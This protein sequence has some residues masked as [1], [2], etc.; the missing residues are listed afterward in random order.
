MAS[1]LSPP[2]G[3]KTVLLFG[4][5]AIQ[6]D[7]NDFCHLR[8]VILDTPDNHWV[9][10]V[11]AELPVYWRTAIKFLPALQALPGEQQLRDLNQWIRS[12]KVADHHFPL[13]YLQHAPLL[14]ITHLLQFAR[15]L[16]LTHPDYVAHGVV[17]TETSPVVEI[18][19]FSFG[20]L[21]AAVASAVTNRSRLQEYGAAG[22]RLALL[23]GALGDAQEI[24]EKYTSLTTV[25]KKPEL[26]GSLSKVLEEH[27]EAYIT[28][29]YDANRA[30]IMTPRSSLGR[31]QQSLQAAG[32]SAY[33][34][35]FNGRYH[36]PGH[37]KL[38][39]G[40]FQMC[41]ADVAL[42]LP[43]A[44]Q[45]PRHTWTNITN[46]PI[47]EGPLH[48]LVLRSILAQQCQWGPTF[49]AVHG[50]QLENTQ[51]IVVE[52]GSERCV[53]P[54]FLR[55]LG[56]RVVH[57][58]DLS[59]DFQSR[60]S[61]L[62]SAPTIYD[63]DIAVV[64]MAC[65][66]AGADDLEE[67]WKILCSGE[68]QHREMPP[69]RY[70]GYETPWRPGAIRPW[71]GNFVSDID[72]FDH[73]FFKKV[74]REV[75]SQ[76]PQQRLFLQVA[77]QALQQAGYFHKKITSKDIGCYVTCCTVDYEH[78]VNCHAA[79]AYAATGLLRSFLAG[80]VSHYFGWHGPA[81]CIDTACSGSA[82]ALHHA[83]RAILQGDCKAALVGGANAITSPLAYD[84]LNGASF[85]SPTG[86]CKPFDEKADGYCRGEGF[87]AIFIKRMS[88]ALADGD[89]I[90][91]TIAATAVEQNDNCTPLVVPH[92][93][94]LA[95]LF[96][97]VIRQSHIRPHEISVVEAHGTGTQAGDPAE[98]SSVRQVMGGPQRA[99]PLTLGSVKGLVGHTEAVS[100]MVALVKVLLMINEGKLPPQPNF[101]TLNPHIQAAADD[102]IEITT[103]LKPWQTDFRAA[104]INNYG[105]CGSNASMVVTQPPGFRSRRSASAIH[106]PDISL[107][108][109]FCALDEHR[110]RDYARKFYCLLQ[111]QIV[112]TNHLASLAN[113]SFNVARQSSPMLDKHLIFSCSSLKELES[114][115]LS[116]IDGDESRTIQMRKSARPVVLCFG[117]QVSTSVGLDR[118]VYDTMSILRKHL[119]E[120]SKIL[121]SLGYEGLYPSIFESTPVTDQV[122][123]QTQLFALQY[124]SARSWMDCGLSVTAVVGHSFGELT[125]LCISE[126]L[127]LE[128]ALI[129]VA[130]RATLIRD[131]WGTNPGAMMAVEGEL[132][133]IEHLLAEAAVSVPTGTSPA[134]IACF[135]SPRSYTLAGATEAMSAVRVLLS[136]QPE[137]SRLKYKSLDVTNAFHS[138]LIDPLIPELMRTTNGLTFREPI[139]HLER[140]T[141]DPCT[142]VPS[143]TIVAEHLRQ[144]VYFTQA[145]ARLA[146]KYKSCIWL[147]AGS[148]STITVMAS[149]ALGSSAAANHRF[150]AVN[151]TTQNGVQSLTDNTIALWKEGVSVSYWAHH[152]SQTPEYDFIFLPPYQFEKSR[153]WMENKPLPTSSPM[154][155]PEVKE[156][157]PQFRF[158]GYQD[159]AKRVA[160]F[161]I[162]TTH[163]SYREAVSGHIG[164]QTAPLAPASFMLDSV[165]EALRSLP[166]GK[167][168]VPQVKNVTSDAPLGLDE[169]QNVHITLTAQSTDKRVWDMEYT[170]E[171][172]EKGARSRVLHCAARIKMFKADDPT[173]QGE[174]SRYGR[175]VSHRRCRELLDS[176]DVDDILQ[177]RNVYRAFSEVVDYA[178]PYRGVHKLVGKGN[179]SAGRVV[180]KYSGRTW[181]DTF[182]CDSFSQVGG[183][184]INCMTDRSASQIY[185]ASGMELWMRTPLYA[186]PE[187]PR[188]ETWDVLATHE[189]GD[190]FYTSDIFVFDSEKGQLV[191]TFI[192]MKYSCVPKAV[193]SKILSK[194]GSSATP[195]R[196][197]GA[198]TTK[199]D[200]AP[201]VTTSEAVSKPK[202]SKGQA[203]NL[204]VRI[205]GVVA[206]FCAV[207]PS[208]IHDDGNMADAGVDS[209]MAMELAR[210]MEEVFKCTL[211]AT[212]LVEAETFR[213][214]VRAVQNAIGIEPDEAAFDEDQSSDSGT[215]SY[216]ECDSESDAIDAATTESVTSMSTDTPELHLP[217]DLILDAFAET[218]ALTDK[219][220][221]ENHCSGRVLS[222]NPVQMQLCVTMTLEAFEEL[223]SPIRSARPGQRLE[224]IKFDAQH[225]ELVQYLYRRLEEARLVQL[226][227][228]AIV[229]TSLEWTTMSS[230]AILEEIGRTYPEFVGASKLAFYTGNK[231]ASVLRGERDGLQLIFG[232]KEGQE[233]VSWMYGDESHNVSGYKQMLDFLQRL[234]QKLGSRPGT[235]PLK[236]LEMGAGT[237]GGTKWF[238]P[239]LAKLGIPIEYTFTDISPAFLAQARRRFKEYPFVQYRVHDIEKPPADDL[240][241]TQHVI[242][243]SNAVHA[244]S[245]LQISTG[246]MRRALRPDG[247]VMM[248]EMTRPQFA[249]DIV[250]GLFRGWWVFNDGRTHAITSEHRWE[251]DLHAVG[252]GHVDW[253]DGHS[254]EASIQRVIFATSTGEQRGRLPLGPYLSH[255]S[256][257]AS[258]DN[259][260]RNQ[261]TDKYI[262]RSI[263]GFTEPLAV[264]T[265]V[266]GPVAVL[267]TGATGS[268]GSH[269]VAHLVQLQNVS[270]V[271]CL[272]R[273]GKKDPFQRQQRAF[274]E[275]RLDLTPQE[276]DKL[277][278]IET[279]MGEKQLG[280][281]E[282]QY[283]FVQTS[284][285]HII[286]NAWP[287]N[288]ARG[289][290]GFDSQFQ[291]MRNLVELARDIASVRP[292]KERVGFQ[293]ISSIGTVGFRPLVTGEPEVPEDRTV[294]DWVLANGYGE[295][296]FVCERTLHHT[297]MKYPKRFNAM[298]VRPGQIAG[299]S[300]SGYWN[301]A[302]HL[303]ALLKS[304]QAI[305]ALPDFGG[306]LSW[307]PV[308]VV[309]A[310]LSE[311]LF[312]EEAHSVYH[313][314]NAA[315]QPWREMMPILAQE[316]G[317]PK[318]NLLPFPEW[319]QRVQ[320]FEGPREDNPAGVMA[321]WLAN[322]FERMSCGGL[323]LATARAQ[324][325]ASTLQS[326]GP[327]DRETVRG[328]VQYWHDHDWRLQYC[329]LVS[330]VPVKDA[331]ST[332]PG[333]IHIVPA[334]CVYEPTLNAV[335]VPRSSVRP[336][337]FQ[338]KLLLVGPWKKPRRRLPST[339][340]RTSRRQRQAGK[341]R[342]QKSLENATVGNSV[343]TTT[344]LSRS[345]DNRA[346][347]NPRASSIEPGEAESAMG[348]ARKICELGSQH[349]DEQNTSAIPGYSGSECVLPVPGTAANRQPISAILG[350]PFP[351]PEVMYSLLDEY[352]DAVHWFSLVIYEPKFRRKL[353]T[354]AD[355]CADPTQRPFLL[356][357]AVVLG[358]AAW[359]RA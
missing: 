86:P 220:V 115:L 135:N 21:S 32:F 281:S 278:V 288:G 203:S 252:Y 211:P 239:T 235:G 54:S 23:L 9:L 161:S 242:I 217:H 111:R 96:D 132:Q 187:T 286:H 188:P 166:E 70:K 112:S 173:L 247:V 162:D 175:L 358:M 237:G 92:A 118:T 212:D 65:R 60:V 189:R 324:Q 251:A 297:L 213:D 109:R 256:L 263:E 179:Q 204:V 309:A 171:D 12:G 20:F 58:G 57:Y 341:P 205:K 159:A 228:G 25:W 113:I 126:V 264:V 359:Y 152:S 16:Q 5:Q 182:L 130:R 100:G 73:K 174:F 78:N 322:N 319:I 234:V 306:V 141:Q 97:K 110:L 253:T 355:G 153:H 120:C 88:D 107:P 119:D 178:E 160:K 190:G 261:A 34:I 3:G 332:N 342:G 129:L 140:A 183:F 194:L 17:D 90:L 329:L 221:S 331:V 150:Q 117:G 267:V 30:T 236:I 316:L 157:R 200:S 89:T 339:H 69:E 214:L 259:V 106:L 356:L 249:I 226:N 298:I 125:A 195:Q 258:V 227:D 291:T 172:P 276:F 158:L 337:T 37:Q 270:R 124:A 87:A 52:F 320:T 133:E 315:R 300:L 164:A 347:Y 208:E 313:V 310:T 255:V 338:R 83:C 61:S 15:Y 95:G 248:L 244:T 131:K 283:H 127:C 2:P 275:R 307:T 108:F 10:D 285:T 64:G 8:Q 289:L 27:P 167:D 14:M 103:K 305:K 68:S 122:K 280:L 176:S 145:I 46:E 29:R 93:P 334:R 36:W 325:D 186:D 192:G 48:Q 238:L 225:E 41:D 102:Q 274:A 216:T 121:E 318:N 348:I 328:Y 75:M 139:L 350:Q 268:L 273:R 169:R 13:P 148:S 99:V 28:V 116:F 336:E 209:L 137:F 346:P 50:S 317:I 302:E 185:I 295:A 312:T 262:R 333:V 257:L 66:V 155:A 170:S 43:D 193:F 201:K 6:F 352:F 82:V 335:N 184:W 231:L 232:T 294:I 265:P 42:Q 284:V 330:A 240:V 354:V 311:L 51:S 55:T 229:R 299:S 277:T 123:L 343:P 254:A 301:S 49:A 287:M 77:Y 80:K 210:E 308:N 149:R 45:L 38:L 224:R 351:E 198:V 223:G 72:A 230:T 290:A 76:D 59:L 134:S 74:P 151:I 218:K 26:E 114:K 11:L 63:D 85:V 292:T 233:L 47:Y 327:V 33:H 35:N 321:D 202:P 349:L 243:A 241:G 303:P 344:P 62:R 296:K 177:G 260:A 91:G 31:L 222:F 142:G 44:S 197:Q 94:S 1:Q 219:F 7:A 180:K 345:T 79:S 147:E 22:I 81:L 146:E 269:L 165:V 323:L 207:D 266:I 199:A 250:F 128:D 340:G 163:P 272:N 353:R 154:N 19:G 181:A 136:T 293:F 24:R 246:N 271:I 71:W 53:P 56:S 18:V 282:K 245:N 40:L 357:L 279:D 39:H 191:E 326:L 168:R 143:P 138:S 206:D 314:D 84:N 67:F 215:A 101:S 4:C 104:L 304:A 98:Y 156:E 144:P 196:A 105:A